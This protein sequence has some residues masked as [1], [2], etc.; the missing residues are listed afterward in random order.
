MCVRVRA[1]WAAREGGERER[2]QI[3]VADDKLQKDKNLDAFSRGGGGEGGEKR[4]RCE[5]H[6]VLYDDIKMNLQNVYYSFGYSAMSS[7]AFFF[8]YVCMCVIDFS[9]YL[10]VYMCVHD[11]IQCVYVFSLGVLIFRKC[12]HMRFTK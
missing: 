5:L 9:M 1:Y 6:N 10:S 7:S 4:G 8:S 12:L 11:F 3:L 2:E